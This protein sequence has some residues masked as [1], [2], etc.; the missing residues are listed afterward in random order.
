MSN[1]KYFSFA[2][3]SSSVPIYSYCQD[4]PNEDELKLES[5]KVFNPSKQVLTQLKSLNIRPE[6]RQKINTGNG[7][8]YCKKDSKGIVYFVL[9][10][11]NYPERHIMAAINSLRDHLGKLGDYE[12]EPDVLLC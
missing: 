2:K 8:W 4:K 1:I 9:C 3:A 7:C 12:S 11:T 5:T 10:S 6:E